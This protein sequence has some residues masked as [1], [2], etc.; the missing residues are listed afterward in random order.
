MWRQRN[1]EPLRVLHWTRPGHVW[2]IDFT[3]PRS[4]V[5]GRCPYLLAARDLASGQQLLWWPCAEAT[6]SQAVEALATLFAI[7]GAPL[8]L[9]ADNGSPFIARMLAQLAHDFGVELL[10]SPPGTPRYN[11][12]IEA[13][14]GSLKMRTEQHAARHGRPDDWTFDDLAAARFEANATSRAHSDDRLTPDESWSH[15]QPITPA[16]RTLFRQAVERQ[17]T[18]IDAQGRPNANP[19]TDTIIRARD[20]QAIRLALEEL[21]ELTYTRRRLP[22]PIRKK[23]AANIM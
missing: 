23:K 5:E 20:R 17:R 18:A 3:G 13:G 7:H 8:V 22:L 12:A 15:R 21:G 19:L 2:A 9:K 1:F 11:G 10:F 4:P 6:A 16:E 14:I